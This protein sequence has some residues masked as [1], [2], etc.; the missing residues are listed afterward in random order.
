M[1]ELVRQ[2]QHP[3]RPLTQG[4]GVSKGIAVGKAWVFDPSVHQ[5]AEVKSQGVEIELTRFRQAQRK[6]LA[7]IEALVQKTKA[8]VGEEESQIFEAHFMILQDE[9]LIG[10][11]LFAIEQEHLSSESA[12][13]KSFRLQ[14][15]IFETSDSD[16]MRERALDLKDLKTQLLDILNPSEK[17]GLSKLLA[18]IILVAEDLTPSQTMTMDRKNVLAIITEKGGQTSHTAIIARTLGIPAVTGVPRATT[19]FSKHDQIALDGEEGSLFLLNDLEMKKYFTDRAVLQYTDKQKVQLLRGKPTLTKDAHMI[20]LYANIGSEKDLDAVEKGDAEGIGLFRT[21]FLFM[22]RKT[23]PTLEDQL[24][25]Y[26][27]VLNK[28]APKEVVI[29]TLD[30]GGD[31]PIPYIKIEKE[32]NPFLG[33]RALRYCLKDIELFKTQIKAMLFA[34]EKANLSIMVPMVSRATEMKQVKE[35]VDTCVAELEKDPRY[36]KKPFKL[37]AMVEIPALIFELAEIKKY[38]SFVSVG[39]NDLLQYSVAADR[40]NPELQNIYNPFNLGFIRMM[41]LLAQQAIAARLEL[42]ICGELG[43]IQEFIP[44]WIGMGYQKLSMIPSEVLGRRSLVSKFSFERCR[45][46][47]AEVLKAKHETDVKLKLTD[48]IQKGEKTT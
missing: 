37:G 7:K 41:N 45:K 16:Y 26:K 17:P 15:Q 36:K 18:P 5:H 28:L 8:E 10:P 1:L 30:V 20:S 4:S 48:F 33:V 11:I 21:E 22:E 3:Y 43:G 14:I 47:L 19:M 35:V 2:T 32:D 42:G 6:V 44:L 34:N 23:A 38:V 31:K 25:V 29:R 9:E 46:L 40:M 13:E 24:R 39:T 12:I 27:T